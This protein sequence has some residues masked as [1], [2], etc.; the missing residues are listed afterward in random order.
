MDFA[1]I[2]AQLNA[3]IILPEGIVLITLLLVLLIDL[4][5]GRRSAQILP[6]IAIG[7]LLVAVVALYLEWDVAD[8][9]AFLGA[10]NGDAMSIVF[11]GIIALSTAVTI[12][13]SIR[14]VQQ[15]GTSLAE[16]IAILLTATLGGMFL[17]GANELVAIFIS[18]ET[19]SISSY[20]LTGYMK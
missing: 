9:I 3:G 19:L 8:P 20:L 5:A 16:F 12:L 4:I 17:S 11:R 1:N 10:F 18:L 14:Y 15:A 13:M 7:G 6:Y 2:A